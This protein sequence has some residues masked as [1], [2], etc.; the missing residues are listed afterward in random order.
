MEE[1]VWKNNGDTSKGPFSAL[2]TKKLRMVYLKKLDEIYFF[3]DSK[4]QNS[5]TVRKK[6]EKANEVSKKY[7]SRR[8]NYPP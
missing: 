8:P 3:V 4:I 5:S 7:S 1:L 2:S 6:M